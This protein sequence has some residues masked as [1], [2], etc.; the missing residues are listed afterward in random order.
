[1]PGPAPEQGG[2]APQLPQAPAQGGQQQTQNNAAPEAGNQTQAGNEQP[3][4]TGTHR[5]ENAPRGMRNRNPGNVKILAGTDRWRGQEGI[6][7]DFAIFETHEEGL[8][9]MAVLL[10]TYHQIQG[11]RTVREILR[12][13]APSTENNTPAYIRHVSGELGVNPDAEIDLHDENTFRTLMNS[14]IQH[15]NGQ[16]PYTTEQIGN[17]IN[18]AWEHRRNR[19]QQ[20][21]GQR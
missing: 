4:V 11:R 3:T 12:P 14:I 7:E 10:T 17:A 8:R 9:A 21:A 5:D 16:N 2:A 1:M 20:R 18:D 15:E 6:D 13:Y 19:E